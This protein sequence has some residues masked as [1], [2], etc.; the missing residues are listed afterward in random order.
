ML[1]NV[2]T[3]GNITC[4]TSIS[5]VVATSVLA[6]TL[7][8]NLATAAEMKQG[9]DNYFLIDTTNAAEAMTFG[10]AVTNPTFNFLGSGITAF[11]GVVSNASQVQWSKGADVASAT[12]LPVLTDGNYF[13]VT[14][15]TTITSINTTAIGTV[16]KLHFDGILILTHDATDLILPT[17]ANITTQVGDEA[18][19]VEYA[20]GDYRCTSYT[21]A[22]G[23]ALSGGSDVGSLIFISTVTA[24]GDATIDIT[25]IDSTF[26][27]YQLHLLN[28]VPTSDASD[29]FLRTS[30]DG[31]SSFDAGAS[32]YD[33]SLL[34]TTGSSSTVD[35][36]A[37]ANH[38]RLATTIGSFTTENGVSAV[39]HLIRP[40]E[41]DFTSV[42]S[43]GMS[44]D[45]LA[46]MSTHI[47][48]G[49]R[50][51]AADVDAIQILFSAGLV[52]SGELKLYGVKKA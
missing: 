48:G 46:R 6:V 11:A 51:S 23:T 29:M 40:A 52:E 12:A 7:V 22:D 39:V 17:G 42:W 41:T 34:R 18:E 33:Y 1:K 10:N 30:T 25:G 27:E 36:S 14:G 50:A 24:S 31:G 15:T 37:A 35:D 49:Q 19:F 8:D 26:D 20:T 43:V 4:N 47:S 45:N 13:D 3:T 5:G 44:A 16:I 28:V 2:T 21:R 9:T 32:D 38:I